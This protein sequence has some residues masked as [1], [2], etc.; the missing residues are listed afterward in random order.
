MTPGGT[1]PERTPM[2]SARI[3]ATLAFTLA[4]LSGLGA[5]ASTTI[6]GHVISAEIGRV[7]VVPKNDERMNDDGIADVKVTITQ[8]GVL[9]K[10]TTNSSGGFSLTVRDD[11]LRSGPIQVTAEG[12]S[13]FRVQNQVQIPNGGQALLVNTVSRT[14]SQDEP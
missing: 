13:I 4:L 10:V 6:H 5:C 3:C 11:A 8:G 1:P 2:S 7:I 12:E 14:P 9:G